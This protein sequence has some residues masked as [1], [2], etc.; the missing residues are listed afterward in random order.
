MLAALMLL[1]GFGSLAL[2]QGGGEPA[3][4]PGEEAA[5]APKDEE[6][7]PLDERKKRFM[8]DFQRRFSDIQKDDTSPERK[9]IARLEDLKK[10]YAAK[11]QK[12]EGDLDRSKNVVIDSFKKL[13]QRNKD[14]EE[15]ETRCESIWIDYLRQSRD[16]K[17][18]VF[19][20]QRGVKG[21]DRRINFIRKRTC[22]GW[23]TRSTT[24]WTT[25]RS[26]ARTRGSTS[27][28]SGGR[29]PPCPITSCSRTSSCRCPAAGAARTGS[30]RSTSRNRRS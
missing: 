3:E 30:S 13:V 11:L 22:R 19:E 25:S 8:D 24:R 6:E 16:N 7:L 18:A 5:P 9:E 29:S 20:Y 14:P 2:A 10:D 26:T 15:V 27:T 28:S 17:T 1:L 21:I 4:G 12:A 23:T